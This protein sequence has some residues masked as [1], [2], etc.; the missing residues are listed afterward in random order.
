M[1]YKNIMQRWK[2]ALIIIIWIFLKLFD[3]YKTNESASQI[4][5]FKNDQFE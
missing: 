1:W 5:F 3:M 4:N 2:K